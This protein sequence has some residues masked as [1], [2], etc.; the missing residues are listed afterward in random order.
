MGES[1][2]KG[3]DEE[4]SEACGP[5]SAGLSVE[6]APFDPLEKFN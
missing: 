1:S 2:G 5:Q 6:A 3:T 4:H